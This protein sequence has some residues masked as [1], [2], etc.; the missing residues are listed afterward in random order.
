M[1]KRKKIDIII[2]FVGLLFLTIGILASCLCIQ[3]TKSTY[4]FFTKAEKTEARIVEIIVS[5]DYEL[6][7]WRT[8]EL[9]YVSYEIDGV[10]YDHVYLKS[11]RKKEQEG[12]IVTIYYNPD[13]PYEIQSIGQIIFPVFPFIFG[14][15]FLFAGCMIFKKE[16]FH[17]GK[18]RKPKAAKICV[19][20][21]IAEI[22]VDSS[23]KRN[24]HPAFYVICE[25][26]SM[27]LY[28]PEF[29]SND[30]YSKLPEYYKSDNWFYPEFDLCT[31]AGDIVPVYI[32]PKKPEEYFI[33]V[34][35]KKRT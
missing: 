8:V 5:S 19:Q 29:Y 21:P 14:A 26:G 4:D 11:D 24:G 28:P 10:V 33:D 2:I 31:K 22:G 6:G 13:D 3:T 7:K 32:N 27:S 17:L 23:V 9:M 35:K 34:K 30:C 20:L 1:K 15:G 16:V 12:D 18:N 25:K